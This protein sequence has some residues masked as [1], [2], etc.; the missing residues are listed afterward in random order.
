MDLAPRY[1]TEPAARARGAVVTDV[2]VSFDL[3]ERFCDAVTEGAAGHV[4]AVTQVHGAALKG[5]DRALI[6]FEWR[7]RTGLL[8]DA[9]S[10]AR[11]G[12]PA[13]ARRGPTPAAA[14][15]MRGC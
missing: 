8:S 12:S 6:G 11:G 3:I 5:I 9:V 15:S 1:A 2:P 10:R 7:R 4:V 14:A 13:R